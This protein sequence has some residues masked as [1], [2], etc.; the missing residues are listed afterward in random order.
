MLVPVHRS[1]DLKFAPS[2]GGGN[3]VDCSQAEPAG[4]GASD[5]AEFGDER[6][7]DYGRKERGGLTRNGYAARSRFEEA[8]ERVQIR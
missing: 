4:P 5:G 6:G 1:P 2:T 3:R 7:R 8:H